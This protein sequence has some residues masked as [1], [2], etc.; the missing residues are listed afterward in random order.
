MC[1]TI[2]KR[3]LQKSS[4][5]EQYPLPIDIS[6][7]CRTGQ[8]LLLAWSP[9]GTY[10]TTFHRQGIQIWGGASWNRMQRFPHRFVRLLDFSPNETY[11]VT[12]SPDPITLPPDG[13]PDRP[14]IPFD[15]SSEGHTIC[16]WETRTGEL[17]RTFPPA[18][19][20]RNY[21]QHGHSLNSLQMKSM[22]HV[23]ILVNKFQFTSYRG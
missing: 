23:Y 11:L 5:L 17:L 18:Q 16:I 10:L 14:N 15:D 20:L 12:W 6:D 3:R 9:L 7:F 21:V 22:L 2:A 19:L 4:N 8:K 13:H 1:V